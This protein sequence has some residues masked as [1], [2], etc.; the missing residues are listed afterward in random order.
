MNDV[1]GSPLL[2]LPRARV[3]GQA[4]N[5][6]SRIQ[7]PEGWEEDVRRQRGFSLIELLIVVAIILIIA[8]IAIPNLLRSRVAANEASAISSVRTLTGAEIMYSALYPTVGYTCDFTRLGPYAGAPSE[9][10]A[11]LIDSVLVTGKKSQYQFT[12]ENCNGNPASTFFVK[13]VPIGGGGIRK[14]CS[15]EPGVIR[16]EAGAGDCT[17]LSPTLQ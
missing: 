11:G 17:D 5:G 12:L 7:G 3:L 8:A 6:G 2:S 10:A 9:N 15:S 13:G 14:F 1:G 16:F 4:E